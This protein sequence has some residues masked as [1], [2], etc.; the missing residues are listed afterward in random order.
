MIH[1]LMNVIPTV[2]TVFLI[3]CYFPQLYMTWKTKDVSTISLSFFA[4]LNIA[5]T[6]LLINSILLFTQNGNWGY[7]VTYI[8]NEGLA[9][10]MLV[11]ILKYRKK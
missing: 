4:M 9:F 8:F 1:T 7:V 3:I 6:L 10:A 11:L 5:L 2:A